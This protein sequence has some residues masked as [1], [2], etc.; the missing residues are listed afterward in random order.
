MASLEAGQDPEHAI[1]NAVAKLPGT[2]GASADGGGIAITKD[3]CVGWAHN[4]PS[5]AVAFITSDMEA[6][7]AWLSK[8]DAKAAG[9]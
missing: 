6:P 1:T 8:E 3:G 7:E 5:F 2:G 4:S 9:T